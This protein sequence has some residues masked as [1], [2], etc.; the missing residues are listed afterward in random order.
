M[1]VP[2]PAKGKEKVNTIF[3]TFNHIWL[4]C[5]QKKSAAATS[6]DPRLVAN[7]A[8]KYPDTYWD[9]FAGDY[10]NQETMINSINEEHPLHLLDGVTI[11]DDG[12][13]F[14]ESRAILSH[15]SQTD[16]SIAYRAHHRH[17]LITGW[18]YAGDILQ[19]GTR[20]NMGRPN[21]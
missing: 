9:Y 8:A 18:D 16:C 20:E 17:D 13:T 1:P 7:L 19:F 15:R 11:R 12:M 3:K 6:F 10:N 5:V 21:I 4:K 2:A 14:F